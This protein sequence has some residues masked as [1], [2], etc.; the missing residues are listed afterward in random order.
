MNSKDSKNFVKS[1]YSDAYASKLGSFGYIIMHGTFPHCKYFAVNHP[2]TIKKA[3]IEA[4]NE[5]SE[6]MMWKLEH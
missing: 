6:A 5:I 2:L 4:A 1:I 3:W